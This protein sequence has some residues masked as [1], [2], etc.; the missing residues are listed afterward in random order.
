MLARERSD[1]V[2]QFAM[3]ISIAGIT[4]ASTTPST[5]RITISD[6]MLLTMPVSAAH[7][8]HRI[9]LTEHQLL[10]AAALGVNRAG[11]LEEEI[12]EE[13][14]RADQR[15]QS[16]ADAE[17]LIDAGGGGEAVVRAIEIREAVGDEDDRHDRPPAA[18]GQWW[19][20]Y[21]A[22]MVVSER[23]SVGSRYESRLIAFRPD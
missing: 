5:K 2:N 11:N 20:W 13:E 12:A 1:F 7:P 17:I 8:P 4:A 14:Q 19:G 3:K 15:R 21:G 9:R 22:C 23:N 10:H 18:Y 16:L 6:G